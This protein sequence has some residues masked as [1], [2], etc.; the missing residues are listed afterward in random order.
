MK[1]PAKTKTKTKAKTYNKSEA[2]KRMKEIED[3]KSMQRCE[4]AI[5]F[6]LDEVES[7]NVK[8]NKLMNRM[9]LE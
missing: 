6:L 4:V 8:I 1:E 3:S 7:I 5:S 9:G 2:K